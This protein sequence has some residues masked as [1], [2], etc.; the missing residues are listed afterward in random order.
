MPLVSTKTIVLIL[1]I[2]MPRDEPDIN[3]IQKVSSFEE[4]WAAAKEFTERDLTED[5]REHGALGLKATCAYQELKS[6]RD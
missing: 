1:S 4:C 6:E 5:M 3:H 2:I